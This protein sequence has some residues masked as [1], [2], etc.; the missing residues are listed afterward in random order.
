MTHVQYIQR[1]TESYEFLQRIQLTLRYTVHV[2]VFAVLIQGTSVH[3]HTKAATRT[4][5]LH[6]AYRREWAQLH[7]VR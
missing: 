6:T 1:T 5:L 4:C 7:P 3:S 2:D